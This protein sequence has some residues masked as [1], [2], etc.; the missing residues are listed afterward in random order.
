[1]NLD[2]EHVQLECPIP[3]FW[4]DRCSKSVG[5]S[6]HAQDAEPPRSDATGNSQL[7][8]HAKE[9]EKRILAPAAMNFPEE[10]KEAMLDLWRLTVNGSRKGL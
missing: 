8:R 6:L 10:K 9:Q 7:V 2:R 1:M 5:Q 3:R 4:T